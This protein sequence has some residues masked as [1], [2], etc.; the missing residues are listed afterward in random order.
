VL[1]CA[2]SLVIILLAVFLF[3]TLCISLLSAPGLNLCT[4]LLWEVHSIL[5][6][7]VTWVNLLHVLIPHCEVEVW[8]RREAKATHICDML[9]NLHLIT[10][11]HVVLGLVT[12]FTSRAIRVL[13]AD[14]V[15]ITIRG[16]RLRDGTGS[17]C[18]DWCT[19]IIRDVDT[20]VITVTACAIQ[21][22]DCTVS[23]DNHIALGY[24]E[25]ITRSTT[26]TKLHIKTRSTRGVGTSR[27]VSCGSASANLT[28]NS[29]WWSHTF[30]FVHV[31]RDVN[32]VK[33]VLCWVTTVLHDIRGCCVGVALVPDCVGHTVFR[34][35]VPHK[36]FNLV[37]QGFVLTG[38]TVR[39]HDV[40]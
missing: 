33:V 9:T 31:R 6:E 1:F 2:C 4:N 23:R 40:E 24:I 30:F 10:L 38:C 16:S 21:V 22:G 11:L 34:R 18:V 15:T 19:H 25:A 20:G 37:A 39:H 27:S 36:L 12:I 14:P 29:L 13:N 8:P 35:V 3:V 32:M 26:G 5:L 7:P 17:R 28:A